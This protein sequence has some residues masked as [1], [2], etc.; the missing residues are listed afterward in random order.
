MFIIK[1]LF[2]VDYKY[3]DALFFNTFI[4]PLVI[5]GGKSAWPVKQTIN[6]RGWLGG[7]LERR[8]P[9]LSFA[10]FPQSV[11]SNY[12]ISHIPP[13]ARTETDLK[14][15][16]R[17]IVDV[18]LLASL[19]S[20][21]ALPLRF[22]L[23]SPCSLQHNIGFIVKMDLLMMLQSLSALKLQIFFFFCKSFSTCLRYS[24]IIC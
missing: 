6:Q 10:T 15:F 20:V 12:V 1:V 24:S 14:C 16:L 23:S 22:L 2:Y 9:H 11:C 17:F 5:S 13:D 21:F 8:Q 4:S 7:F 19:I 18:T 3:I